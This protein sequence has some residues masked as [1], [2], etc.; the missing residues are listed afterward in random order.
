MKG[1][2]LRTT[3]E[4]ELIDVN[5]LS[6]M[7]G[8]VGGYIEHVSLPNGGSMYVNEEGKIKG[9]PINESATFLAEVDPHDVIVGDVLIMGDVND[10]GDHLDI[11]DD[12]VL[13]VLR[14]TDSA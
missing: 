13:D 10:E 4:T 14:W 6:T 7:Q 5:G 3:G 8:V 12:Q 11:S 9:L 1:L 2:V